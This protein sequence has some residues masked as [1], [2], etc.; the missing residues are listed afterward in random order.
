ML[1]SSGLYFILAG[2]YGVLQEDTVLPVCEIRKE[3]K[4]RLAPRPA[5]LASSQQHG[6][7]RTATVVFHKSPSTP[8]L[9]PATPHLS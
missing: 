9:P 3:A 1:G 5:Q 8:A 6:I 2:R 4:E 7:P